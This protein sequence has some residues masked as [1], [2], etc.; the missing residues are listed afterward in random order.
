MAFSL[1]FSGD[2][3]GPNVRTIN[4]RR[5]ELLDELSTKIGQSQAV[6]GMREQLEDIRKKQR[7]NRLG[8]KFG[9]KDVR[10]AIEAREAQTEGTKAQTE[11][12]RQV[13]TQARSEAAADY[14]S[15]LDSPEGL[16]QF[17]NKFPQE[18]KA[19]GIS[20]GKYKDI[21]NQIQSAKRGMSQSRAFRERA[22][23]LGA[24]SEAQTA[25]DAI[26]HDY[27]M[28]NLKARLDAEAAMLQERLSS[29]EHISDADRRY[30]GIRA[31]N[32][33]LQLL[34]AATGNLPPGMDPDGTLAEQAKT[35]LDNLNRIAG[36][37]AARTGSPSINQINNN[38]E[39]AQK[40]L[41]QMLTVEYGMNL[42]EMYSDN[43][44]EIEQ[45]WEGYGLLEQTAKHIASGYPY[46]PGVNAASMARNKFYFLEADPE[47]PSLGG[48]FY[49]LP[50][51]IPRDKVEAR[52]KEWVNQYGIDTA[53][54]KLQA[55]LAAVAL[56][57]QYV[58]STRNI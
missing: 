38:I 26:L 10:T 14:A 19:L 2:P 55:A 9:E 44:K 6:L 51:S 29:A 8:E 21:A 13:I 32:T 46:P 31:A 45:K 34:L 15:L 37:K 12:R 50:D 18:S 53:R 42:G 54:K 5:R 49:R 27:N 36:M 47:E 35:H 4:T 39:S 52:Y 22:A 41:E 48:K 57:P 1:D 24:Q 28:E 56:N 58:K 3:R 25:R 20:S 30:A 16:E 43:P 7:M 33:D 11:G 17:R 40:S 23:I